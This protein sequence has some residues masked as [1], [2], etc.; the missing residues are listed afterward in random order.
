MTPTKKKT[1]M[2][3]ARDTSREVRWNRVAA[4]AGWL[5][6]ASGLACGVHGEA[7]TVGNGAAGSSQTG[8][9]GNISVS[10]ASG[11]G[12]A[13][14][15]GTT[16]AAGT[17]TGA[18]G[19]TTGADGSTTGAAGST[20]AAGASGTG[21]A[22]A[23]GAAGMAPLSGIT[24]NIG[25]T[26]VPKENVIAFINFGHSNMAGRGV[27]PADQRTFFFGA[28]DP[29]AWMYHSGKGFQ[30][31]VEPNTAGDGGNMVN[32]MVSGGLSTPLVKQAAALAPG[33]YFV[34][35][36]FAQGSAYCS[37][38]LPNA[39]YYN[40]LITGAKELKGK[41]TF[42]GI[43][44]LLGITERHGTQAD[45]NN[46]PQ[47]I[48]TLVTA[49]RNDLGEPNLPLLLND[50]EMGTTGPLAPT[51]AFALAIRPKILMVPSVVT[52]SFIIPTDNPIVQIEDD[53]STDDD[54]HFS[55]GG[56]EEYARRLLQTMKD[57]GF[58]PW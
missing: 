44:I 7:D 8:A 51:S 38:F 3:Q 36:P 11:N 9:A 17:T 56:H 49:I 58:F 1:T 34:T 37:Q 40:K 54:H 5:V 41:V 6:A 50:Y 13:G 39:L 21:A 46:Y 27:S 48:S 20:G 29:H 53:K 2:R 43:V 47:C 32:G 23:S 4:V 28:P 25:G 16:G 19:S 22:G 10:G 33:K 42:A 35:I 52:N 24:V 18:A 31:A 55:L 30:P 15:V 26:N 14:S 12:A 57:K 45:I